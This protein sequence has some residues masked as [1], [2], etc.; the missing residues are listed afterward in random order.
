MTAPVPCREGWRF[1]RPCAQCDCGAASEP[2]SPKPIC[3]GGETL[4]CATCRPGCAWYADPSEPALDLSRWAADARDPF[5]GGV[6]D[7]YFMEEDFAVEE[8]PAP[9]PVLKLDPHQQAAV[10]HNTG[11]ALCTAGAGSG[12][13][14]VLTERISRLLYQGLA[15]PE[16][17]LAVTFSRKATEELRERIAGRIGH[18]TAEKI[19]VSTF[20]ALG[21][22]LCREFCT[23]I[24]RSRHLTVW[25]ERACFSEMSSAWEE[26]VA[27]LP[28]EERLRVEEKHKKNSPVRSLLKA[29]DKHKRTPADLDDVVGTLKDQGED[30]FLYASAIYQYEESKRTCNALDYDDLIWHA[31]RLLIYDATVREKVQSRWAFVLVDEYQDT[32]R[33]Q[34]LMMQQ[35]AGLHR[36][37]FVVGDD[38]Q[39]I[40]RWRGAEPTNL[41]DFEAD[42]PG[43]QIYPLGRNY[44]STPN[45]VDWAARSIVVNLDRRAKRIWS[46]AQP[47]PEVTVTPARDLRGEADEAVS[48]LAERLREDDKVFRDGA[49]LVRT[50]RQLLTMQGAAVRAKIPSVMV[51]ALAWHQRADARLILAWLRA[52]WNPH[53]M[54]AATTI[55]KGWPGVGPKSVATWRQAAMEISGDVLGA[56]LSRVLQAAPQARTRDAL[57]RIGTTHAV[58]RNLCHEHVYDC[59]VELYTRIGLLASIEAQ[60]ASGDVQEALDA[61]SREEVRDAL[62]GLSAQEP[63]NGIEGI[64]AFLDE[65]ATQAKR[66]RLDND[67]LGRITISTIHASKG[68]EWHA[69]VVAGAT[70]GLLPFQKSVAMTEDDED[71]ASNAEDERRLYYVACTRAKRHLMLSYPTSLDV[72]GKPS[73]AASPSR[74]LA[75]SKPE[76]ADP[77]PEKP[78][79]KWSRST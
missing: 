8:E 11:P 42:W 66:E 43:A 14:R 52:I 5:G 2:P 58:L 47:G 12:K 6:P 39:A 71:E 3:A 19:P 57:S 45:I 7:V 48:W 78:K 16:E 22:S 60:K 62:F 67:A 56:P 51:G 73:V 29:I 38:D 35:I 61:T 26:I 27:G 59:V 4:P 28:E 46:E 40:Y 20:H 79:R 41:I 15:K 76:A 63:T 33:I 55:L 24:G 32:S 30:R 36:N 37:I 54:E 64:R 13:T 74:F 34:A 21:L 25:D 77:Q 75:E 17:V 72:P 50:R 69:V 10:D 31:A 53:D 23:K 68:L 1:F 44:R 49:V 65:I 70:E 18:E 9:A